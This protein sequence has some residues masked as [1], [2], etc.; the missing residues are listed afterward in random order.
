M[1]KR[2]AGSPSRLMAARL[3]VRQKE[4]EVSAVRVSEEDDRC[5]HEQVYRK[6]KEA[7]RCLVGRKEGY[8]FYPFGV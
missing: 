4:A 2:T 8:R 5:N 7:H 6:Q 3:R 1:I